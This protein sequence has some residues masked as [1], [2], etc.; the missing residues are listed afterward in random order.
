MRRHLAVLSASALALSTA[1][2]A[3]SAPSVW[4]ID[5]GEKIKRDAT[6]LGFETGTGNPVWGPGAPLKLFGMRNETIAFQIV[7]E[8]DATALSGVTVELDALKTAG[9]A[10]IAN[11]AGATDPM[12]YVGRPIERFVE[13][14]FQIKRESATGTTSESLGWAAGSGPPKGAWTGWMPD[15][16]IPVEVA[17]SWAPYPM[18]VGANENRV[19]W[20]DVTVPKDQAAGHYTGNVV[21]KAGTTALATIPIELDVLSATL[22]EWPVKTMLFYDRGGD[23]DPRIAGGDAAEKQLWQLYHRHRLSPMHGADAPGDVAGKLA[24]LDGSLY[25]AANGYDGPAIGKGDGILSLGT[26]GSFGAPSSTKL[27]N[28]EKIADEIQKAGLFAT[29]DVFLYAID[30]TC[31]STYGAQ[32]KSLIAGSSNANVKKV[33]VGWTCS[34]DPSKQPVDLPIVF[35]GSF[36]AT[37]AAAARAAGKDVWIYNGYRPSTGTFL[38]DSE[39]TSLRVNGWIAATTDIGRWFYWETAFWY[40]GN[41]GGLGPYDPFV[42]AETFHNSDG[43]QC[44]GDGVLVYPGKQVDLFTSHSIGFGGALASIRLKNF[45]RGIEDAGYFQLAHAADPAKADAIAKGVLVKVL[46]DATHGSPTAYAQTGKPWFDA[47]KA[48][49]DLIPKDVVPPGGDT[50]PGTDS[51]PGADASVPGSDSGAPGSDGGGPGGDGSTNA[52]EGGGGS[53]GC[54][55]DLPGRSSTGGSVLALVGLIEVVRRRRAIRRARRGRD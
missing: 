36:N 46:G 20:I 54:G 16:L 11:A 48:L 10:T 19:V 51:G 21:V 52:D 27:A 45:R 43:D 49:A 6:S 44:Q 18:T 50:G 17:P 53:S 3:R 2:P 47:R 14:Y 31:S 15:A 4:A 39:A 37:T 23:L 12:K 33:K 35:A 24:A 7:V 30:E 28:V 26:Y 9:G 13:S 38:T 25:T 42:T 1:S 41:R 34:T 8:A 32:W 40:D 29:T 22:P 5:D 55:C